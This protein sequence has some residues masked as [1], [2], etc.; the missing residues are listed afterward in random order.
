MQSKFEDLFRRAHTAE[1]L[2]SDV[3]GG[4]HVD[5]VRP[6]TVTFVLHAPHK[7]FISVVGDFNGW[8]TRAHPLKTDGSGTWWT[9]LRHPG[10]TRYG[11]YVLVDDDTHAWVGDPYA[12]EVDWTPKAPWGVLGA[13][14]HRFRWTDS[15]WRTPPLRDLVIYEACVRD[16]AGVWHGNRPLYGNFERLRS[17]IPHMVRTGVNAVELMP[18]QAF[19]GDSSWGYNP[20]FYHAI[21]NTYGS[22]LDFKAFVNE[23]HRS[24]IA[25]ILDVAFNHAWGEH[26]YYQMYPPMY[27]PNGERWADWNPFFHHT[28]SAINMWG[29][30]DWDHFDPET[31]R[32]FQDVVRF[33]LQEY[34]VDG[35]RFDW[36][37]GVDYDHRNPH[38][39]G[40]NPYHGISAICWAAK[41]V[42]PDCIL[43]GEF[44]TLEG[45][46]GDK[47]AQKLVH[48][49]PM[50]AVWNGYFHHNM[51]DVLN[52]RWQW[53]KK[54]I[55]R[56]IGGFRELGY[57]SA[58]QVINYT[59]SHDEVRPEHEIKFYS[60]GHVERPKGMG[61]QDAALALARCGLVA[62][63]S[64]PGVPMI[65]AGQ[66]YGE[67]SP[68]T[69]DFAPMQ[70][71][72]MG[73]KEGAEHYRVVQR[74]IRAR[75]THAALRSDWIEFLPTDFAH[76]KVVR[77]RRWDAEGRGAVVA[78][79]FGHETRSVG[80]PFPHLGS[81]RDVVSNRSR[82]VEHE[83]VTVRLGPYSA[84][85]Y[86]PAVGR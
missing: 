52:H 60:A 24:G 75:R 71:S 15:A 23:C 45:T 59:A 58:T 57:V 72:K 14:P 25:V 49:T 22:P 83:Y 9:T 86:V 11:F 70:W 38:E 33:W 73:R 74:L 53:E 80:L 63:L 20:V 16:A 3:R 40:F 48:E 77:F 6:G 13:K 56:T 84:V 1:R 7:P 62:L 37:G 81:W 61:I 43:V 19:P 79:N 78:I 34:H 12:T 8:D 82:K 21:A 54:D 4:V 30:V 47:T 31:T 67:D 44:W 28:P 76:E 5:L 41:A 55:C 27:G 85:L 68:R 2:P 10:Q 18:I 50:D 26:P 39:P 17:L 35:F 64:A 46:H 29:G 66:E 42:K 69:I 32:Y 51:E 65:Y 36:V